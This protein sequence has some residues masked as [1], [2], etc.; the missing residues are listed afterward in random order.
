VIGRSTSDLAGILATSVA[1]RGDGC[2][3]IDDPSG[4][5]PELSIDLIALQGNG[6]YAVTRLTDVRRTGAPS[7]GP[8][9]RPEYLPGHR[10]ASGSSSKVYLSVLVCSSVHGALSTIVN[11]SV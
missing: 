6:F 8:D 2:V 11:R 4:R 3:G 5:S 1:A 10:M 9:G 7:T